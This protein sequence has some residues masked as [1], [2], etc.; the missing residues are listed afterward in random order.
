[1]NHFFSMMVCGFFAVFWFSFGFLQ[2]PTMGIAAS[3][4]A[5]GTNAAEGAIS[6]GYTAGIALYLVA[7]GAALFTIWVF[8]LKMNVVI[9]LIMGLATVAVYTLSAAYFTLGM[10]DFAKA[11]NLQHVS[12]LGPSFFLPVAD[13]VFLGWWS[14]ALRCGSAG[15]VHDG[16]DYECR[17]GHACLVACR[18][19]VSFLGEAGC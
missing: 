18:R 4:S 9:C 2:L 12:L 7:L 5:T 13:A 10:G 11:T 16:G 14:V 3:F 6:V 8:T 1:M 19:S 17:A 15:L